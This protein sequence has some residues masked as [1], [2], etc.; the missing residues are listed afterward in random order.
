MKWS[1]GIYSLVLLVLL[2]P[3]LLGQDNEAA[4]RAELDKGRSKRL[5][6]D[7]QSLV[8]RRAAMRDQAK[9]ITKLDPSLQLR[10]QSAYI[11]AVSL[12][13]S[14]RA[15][16]FSQ[17]IPTFMR[18]RGQRAAQCGDRSSN[19]PDNAIWFMVQD[20][21]QFKLAMA[22]AS[23]QKYLEANLDAQTLASNRAALV[24]L[25]YDLEKNFESMR[26]KI[27]WLGRRSAWEHQQ[28]LDFVRLEKARDPYNPGLALIEAV[29]HRSNGDFGKAIQCMDDIDNLNER[30]QVLSFVLRLQIEWLLGNKENSETLSRELFVIG[31]EYGMVEPLLVRGWIALAE[32]NTELSNDCGNRIRNIAPDYVEGTVLKAWS[33]LLQP[34]PASRDASTMLLGIAPRTNAE[35]WYFHEVLAYAYAQR[36]Q[37]TKAEKEIGIAVDAAP[38][39]L[40]DY[41]GSQQTAIASRN[42]PQI[43]MREHLKETWRIQSP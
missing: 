1:D 35:D 7:L 11:N 29:A 36:E 9:A 28:S 12:E 33:M 21:T 37:W 25:S 42:L 43:D 8:Q 15:T 5:L 6:D 26:E 10:M 2:S 19:N 4:Q 14:N 17:A 39:H 30:M 34:R 38:S 40:R 20:N 24:Q 23:M 27:D 31:K 22:S 3:T 41:L 16:P 32:G 13:A 18:W